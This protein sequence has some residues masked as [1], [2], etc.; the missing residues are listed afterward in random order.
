MVRNVHITIAGL[1]AWLRAVFIDAI[2][3]LLAG[4]PENFDLSLIF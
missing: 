3:T 4:P 2:T 1:V